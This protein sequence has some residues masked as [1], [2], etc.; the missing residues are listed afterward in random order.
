ME[1][2]IDAI[3]AIQIILF[4][5][6]QC[7]STVTFSRA[8]LGLLRDR[9]KQTG[10]KKATDLYTELAERCYLLNKQDYI[11]KNKASKTS[12]STDSEVPKEYKTFK[13]ATDVGSGIHPRFVISVTKLMQKEEL[14]ETVQQIL[15][16]CN[17]FSTEFRQNLPDSEI[18]HR[19]NYFATKC[20]EIRGIGPLRG[21][22][23]VQ[24][25]ALFGLVPLQFYTYLPIHLNG[26]PGGFMTNEMGWTDEGRKSNLLQWNTD[27]LNELQALYNK[28]FTYNMFENA[29]CEISRATSP[30]DLCYKIPSVT[31]Y[32]EKTSRFRLDFE[33]SRLQF[34]FR[35]DGNRNNNWKLQMFGGGKNKISVF[36]EQGSSRGNQFLLEWTRA[37]TN[38]YHLKGAFGDRD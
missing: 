31:K 17:K 10:N 30:N 22:M 24:L 32:D 38:Q 34:F 16:L 8:F 12:S 21:Q 25:C 2:G 13:E 33:T 23:M 19:V 27:I 18:L 3:G 1:D 20:T 37:Q 9:R 11:Q 28:E 36:G 15:D 7:N 6:H 14:D 29:A 26:G 35:V 4:F 5:C